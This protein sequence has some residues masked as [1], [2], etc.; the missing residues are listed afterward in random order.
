MDY[1][2][3]LHKLVCVT[4][5]SSMNC[6]MALS[7]CHIVFAYRLVVIVAWLSSII[8]QLLWHG[9]H[10][11]SLSYCR[12]VIAYHHIDIYRHIETVNCHMDI[13]V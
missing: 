1:W 9:Y 7:T 10:L 12:L 5:L 8:T 6:Q 11:L 13:V 2:P 4:W 3:L